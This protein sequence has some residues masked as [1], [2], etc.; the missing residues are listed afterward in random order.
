MSTSNSPAPVS[1]KVM[2][3]IFGKCA[4][5]GVKFTKGETI[6]YVPSEKRAYHPSSHKAVWLKANG[7]TITVQPVV[8]A[9]RPATVNQTPAP[10]MASV[11]MTPAAPKAKRRPVV[12][13]TDKGTY[14]YYPR[15]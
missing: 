8:R 5:T 7:Q 14:V 3:A 4:E 9:V 15:G 11:F 10:A 12:R 13:H 2:P 6:F 1:Y